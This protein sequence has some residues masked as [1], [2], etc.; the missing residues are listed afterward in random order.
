MSNALMSNL[1]YL[2]LFPQIWA[3]KLKSNFI[4]TFVS[5]F[6]SICN[7]RMSQITK[8]LSSDKMMCVMLKTL[9]LNS[10]YKRLIYT[11]GLVIVL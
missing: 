11:L 4:F 3:E 2:Y 8:R 1:R 10:H 7:V 9:L 6:V 5:G